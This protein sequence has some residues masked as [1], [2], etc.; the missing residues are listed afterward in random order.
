VL[1]KKLAEEI[2]GEAPQNTIVQSYLLPTIRAAIDLRENKPTSAIELLRPTERYELA[3]PR[4]FN[5]VYPAYI[6]GLAYLQIG[7]GK[8]AAGEFQKLIDH[9]ALVGRWDTRA[10][11]Y[12][13][14][15][16]AR[17]M[18]GDRVGAMK[19]YQ[20]FLTIWKDADA[21]LPTLIQAKAEYA[22][23]R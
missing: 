12:L 14:L 18:M 7:Q 19:S 21:N 6:R 13:Q 20:D 11:S 5:S 3:Y 8:Q 23:L 2:S 17:V 15:G 1:S 10:L 9:P 16:R 4:S 22:A